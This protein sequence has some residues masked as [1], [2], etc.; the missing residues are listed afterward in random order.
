MILSLFHV[1]KF[2]IFFL[3]FDDQSAQMAF[4]AIKAAAVVANVK[5]LTA[6]NQVSAVIAVDT[7]PVSSL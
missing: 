7:T 5:P 3:F 2:I 4:K 6:D 1:L